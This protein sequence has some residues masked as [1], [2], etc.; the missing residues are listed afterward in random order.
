MFH[1]II[2][3]VI[4]WMYNTSQTRWTTHSKYVHSSVYNLCLHTVYFQWFCIKTHIKIF[5]LKSVKCPVFEEWASWRQELQLVVHILKMQKHSDPRFLFREQ[6]K[7][8][9]KAWESRECKI[10]NHRGTLE[11]QLI[12]LSHQQLKKKNPKIISIKAINKIQYLFMIKNPQQ[13]KN[14]KELPHFDKEHL[15]RPTTNILMLIV[16]N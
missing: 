1:I 5:R 9:G 7:Q 13:S 16:R 10:N 2:L 6:M 8:N 4:I 14:R 3:V 15:Q 11:N 12:T